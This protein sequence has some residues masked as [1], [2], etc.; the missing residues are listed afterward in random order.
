MRVF[1]DSHFE[2][3]GADFF[4]VSDEGGDRLAMS[5]HGAVEGGDRLVVSGDD[6]IMQEFDGQIREGKKICPLSHE[7]RTR[8]NKYAPF[9][10][11]SAAGGRD[12]SFGFGD[13]LGTA[14]FAHLKSIGGRGLFPVLAQQSMRELT[15]MKRSYEDVIDAAAWAVFKAGWKKG[16]GADGDHLKTIPDIKAALDFGCS[17]ITLDCSEKLGSADGSL[18]D[19]D[20]TDYEIRYL[21]KPFLP[22]LNFTKEALMKCVLVYAEAVDF[23]SEV[24]ETLIKPCG[25]PID[26]EISIDETPGVTEPEAHFFVANELTRRGVNI[27]SLAPRFT[28]EF[29]KAIDYIGDVDA[30]RE[31]IRIHNEIAKHFGYR[32]SVHS[33]S[34]KFKVFPVISEE[35][36]GRF[37]IKTS[38]TSWLEAVRMIAKNEPA[39]Y[40][41]MHECA[42]KSLDDA[43]KL[44]VVHC[45]LARVKP[46]AEVSDADLPGYLEQDDS[47]QLMHITYGFMFDDPGLRHDIYNALGAHKD[48][49][50]SAIVDHMKKHFDLLGI[51]Q[52]R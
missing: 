40:R 23:A 36:Q 43:K 25:R 39:L 38:G 17:M 44:Y 13:R 30:F 50:E 5:G 49:Y 28:G 3:G 41:K 20:I 51:R 35:T 16:F 7:N 9:T 1:E 46:L 48:D 52:D 4:I 47:R 12:V 19:M 6:A 10:N 15:S 29:Q 21:Y 2:T 11:P 22:G 31:D 14:N 34:D 24:Y 8:L 32:I 27:T 37:H 42:L 26:F 18:N 33:G 45:D